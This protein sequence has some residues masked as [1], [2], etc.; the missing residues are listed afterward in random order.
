M[1][2]LGIKRKEDEKKIIVVYDPLKTNAWSK[3]FI[4]VMK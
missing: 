1:L 4:S 3:E 2:K